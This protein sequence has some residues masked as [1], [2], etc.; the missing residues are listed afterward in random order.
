MAKQTRPRGGEPPRQRPSLETLPERLRCL[1]ADA[2]ATQAELADFLR[3]REGYVSELL[4]GKKR[5]NLPRFIDLCEFL[6]LPASVVLRDMND[7]KLE[8]FLHI[9][10]ALNPDVVDW[11]LGLTR[12]EVK[13]AIQGARDA[14]DLQRMRAR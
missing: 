9:S 7:A 4:H 11:M 1:L 2:G 8:A 5:W 12:A 6:D 13:V 3:L 14:V 10:P